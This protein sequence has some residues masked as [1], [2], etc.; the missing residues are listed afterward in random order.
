MKSKQE[1]AL[2]SF[3]L[4]AKFLLWD[5][6]LEVIKARDYML[7][8]A[9]LNSIIITVG[10]VT[11]LVVFGAMVGFVLQRRKSRWNNV[12][13]GF[14]LAGLAREHDGKFQAAAVEHGW[15]AC[16]NL[17]TRQIS[18]MIRRSKAETLFAIDVG[19]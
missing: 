16:A 6:F 17:Q 1:A 12:I 18:A 11:L 9:D 19:G 3:S 10:A 7:L 2:M 13:Y 4:P 14:V 5:N 15:P 8:T